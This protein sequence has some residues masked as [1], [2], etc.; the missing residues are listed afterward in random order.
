MEL[1]KTASGRVMPARA[2]EVALPSS[3]GTSMR[4][5]VTEPSAT[6]TRAAR[7]R[8]AGMSKRFTPSS[9][10]QSLVELTAQI[11]TLRL[12]SSSTRRSSRGRCSS[13]CGS[14][15]RRGRRYASPLRG[16]PGT[17][18]PS[19]RRCRFGDLA[20]EVAAVS[21]IDPVGGF[22]GDEAG[23]DAPVHEAG[24]GV[25]GPEGAV[26]VEDGDLGERSRT[27]WWNSAGVRTLGED[28]WHG[29][30]ALHCAGLPVLP[31]D[32]SS[33]I[34]SYFTL[35][36]LGIDECVPRLSLL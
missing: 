2:S 32:D 25:A 18:G 12:R 13:R 17:S 9:M 30:S 5:S 3:V 6:W 11:S 34:C 31:R 14:Q 20:A 24:A 1:P 36:G 8:L 10:T 21:G 28:L 26:A 27:A 23:L 29:R 33:V 35:G 4:V 22:A 16:G 7:T 19:G 15:R